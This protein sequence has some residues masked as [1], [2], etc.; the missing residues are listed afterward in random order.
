MGAA[1]KGLSE[2]R[3]PSRAWASDEGDND[4]IEGNDDVKGKEDSGV[5]SNKGHDLMKDDGQSDGDVPG[6]SS[7]DGNEEE[8]GIVGGNEEDLDEA[9]EGENKDIQVVQGNKNEDRKEDEQDE[10]D[11]DAIEGNDD[12]K[13]KEDSGVHSNKGHDLMKDDGQSDGDVPGDSSGDGNEEEPGIVGGN[14]E[15][16]D[17][18]NEGENKDIQVVQGNK[19]EDRKEDEQDEGDNDAIEGNDDVKGKE[20]SGVHSNKGHDLMKDD[21]QSDGDVPGDSSGDGN[22]EE[23]GIVGG[24]E[25]DLDEANEGENKDIQVVQGNKNEDRKEDEQGNMAASEKGGSDGGKEESGSGGTKDSED[26]QDAGNEQGILLVDSI[27]WPVEDLKKDEGDNDAIEGNDDVKGKEDSGVHSNKGHDLMKDDGQSDGDV[28]GD[29]SGDGNEEEPGIVGGN[30]EDLDEANEGENKDIQVVQ[31]NKNED[32]KED[33]QGNMAASEKG[34]SDGG[35]EESGSGGTKDSEDTQDA[36]NEQ[37]IL[38]VDSIRWPVEDLKKDEG[39]N[40]AIEGNDDVKGKEDSGVHSN[41]GHDLMKDDGQSD[42]DVPGDSSGDGNEE[43]PGIVGGNEEDLDEANEG[44]NKDIQV[45]Q[46]NKNEDRKE[47]EQDEGD[48]DAIEGNDDV[49]GKEDSGVHS[50]KGHDLMK[51]DGQS[52]GDVP[53]DSSGDGN[54]EEPGI[55]GGNEEDL[56]EANEGENKDIQVVQGNKNEDRKEDEQ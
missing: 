24:N 36:G 44:E 1:I 18:A 53:G 33:E 26:T 30:E 41:K 47:D 13:G 10:G 49:K 19:N 20:D 22:E 32:R 21:G 5:H 27:R 52:D 2:F 4:A 31:G 12:V 42:G 55:V 56:D 17:E 48:N 9:N 51:D 50:N 25:E 43:E 28:P 37:G 16:L 35:K 7:G 3:C 39:D 46:G 34:G 40:D 8:P 29:S 23:P 14:E 15:D 38:L 11:N 54:E 45:V 6:D